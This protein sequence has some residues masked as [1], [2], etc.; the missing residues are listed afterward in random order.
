MSYEDAK[1]NEGKKKKK[2]YNSYEY[3]LGCFMHM[4]PIAALKVGFLSA[5]Q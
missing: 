2:K 5:V 1:R 3:Q 4:F